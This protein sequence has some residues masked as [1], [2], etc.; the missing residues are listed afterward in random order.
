MQTT[1]AAAPFNPTTGAEYQGKNS[2]FL[3]MAGF[4]SPEWATYVQW[5]QL[6]RQVIKGQHGTSILAVFSTDKKDKRE[7]AARYYRVFN[8]EQTEESEGDA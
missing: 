8:I 1:I 7:R 5:Q 6:G 2:A 4:E 3:T